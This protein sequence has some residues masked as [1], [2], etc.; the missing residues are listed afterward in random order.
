VQPHATAL[1]V[2]ISAWHAALPK[3]LA[4]PQPFIRVRAAP[5]AL[6]VAFVVMMLLFIFLPLNENSC[7]FTVWSPI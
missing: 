7:R 2:T 4:E 3:Q 1:W 5:A 6:Q